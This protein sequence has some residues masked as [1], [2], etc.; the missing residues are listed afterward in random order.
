MKR[1]ISELTFETSEGLPV[2]VFRVQPEDAAYL[3]DLKLPADGA[4]C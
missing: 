3:V 4:T 2:E 1:R